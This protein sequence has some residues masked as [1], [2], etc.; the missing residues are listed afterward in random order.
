MSGMPHASDGI[1]RLSSSFAFR[2]AAFAICLAAV[3]AAGALQDRPAP[4]RAPASALSPAPAPAPQLSTTSLASNGPSAP[5]F[6]WTRDAT[7]LGAFRLPP[8]QIA[9]TNFTFNGTG[10]AYNAVANS[11]FMTGKDGDARNPVGGPSSGQRV[12]E[13]S[14]PDPVI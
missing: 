6:D 8:N 12:A 3:G 10:L 5:L 2:F 1:R 7:Y 11:L 13:I 14:I 9:G 4:A